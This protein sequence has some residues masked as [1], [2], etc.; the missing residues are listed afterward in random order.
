M[1]KG[2]GIIMLTLL[3]HASHKLQT[4]HLII[5]GP[6]KAY[7]GASPNHWMLP[8]PGTLLTINDVAGIME[9]S[10]G[11]AVTRYNFEKGFSMTRFHPLNE[12][13]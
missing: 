6:R 13:F 9:K 7:Y 3:L 2:N 8:N 12:Q 11:K 5:F 4:S 10:F 1:A